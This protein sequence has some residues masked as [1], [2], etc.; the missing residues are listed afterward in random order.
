MSLDFFFHHLFK[1]IDN[2]PM[3]LVPVSHKNAPTNISE[4]HNRSELPIRKPSVSL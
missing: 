2:H 3:F 1:Y 4:V